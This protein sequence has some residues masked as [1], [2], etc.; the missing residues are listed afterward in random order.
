MAALPD[1]K[2]KEMEAEMSRFEQEI[3][4]PSMLPV[5]SAA[6][7]MP[8]TSVQPVVIPASIPVSAAP[9]IPIST[10]PAFIPHQLQIRPKQHPNSH[11]LPPPPPPPMMPQLPMPPGAPMMGGPPMGPM[12]PIPPPGPPDMGPMPMPPMGMPMP[13]SHH[14]IPIQPTVISKPPTVYSA[15]PVKFSQKPDVSQ[16]NSGIEGQSSSLD[17]TSQMMGSTMNTMATSMDSGNNTSAAVQG[18]Y[19]PHQGQSS[20]VMKEEKG[21]EGKV[22]KKQKKYIRTAAGMTWE[23]DSLNDWDPSDFRIFC[24]DLGNEV[25]DEILTRVFGKYQSFQ[26]AK[27][28]RDKRTNKTKGFGFVSFKDPNDFIAAMREM[29]GKYVGNRPIKLRKSTWSDR[30]IDTVR[31]KAKEKEKLGLR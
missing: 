27:V 24:G 2:R 14:M 8:A 15:P 31:K 13:H 7:T 6:L 20:E 3:L 28:V 12:V 23:D 19:I 11:H 29:N 1:E 10:R 16:S 22:A 30:N 4:G 25:T 18:P 17:P 21:K 9:S 26:R 5:I